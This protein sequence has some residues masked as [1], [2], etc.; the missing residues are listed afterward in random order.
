MVEGKRDR[1]QFTDDLASHGLYGQ[2]WWQAGIRSFTYRT[3]RMDW[4][5]AGLCDLD[6]L[7]WISP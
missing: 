2:K 6:R 1:L 5:I 4:V 3:E 7:K